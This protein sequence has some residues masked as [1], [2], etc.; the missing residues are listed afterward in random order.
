MKPVPANIMDLSKMAIE[1]FKEYANCRG[2]QDIILE[3]KIGRIN[4]VIAEKAYSQ[5]KNL[6]LSLLSKNFLSNTSPFKF[7]AKLSLLPN[8][9]DLQPLIIPNLCE[10][11][12]TICVITFINYLVL[13]LLL[14]CL[15]VYE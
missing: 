9:R 15:Y 10:Y 2:Y 5:G 8:Q 7:V 12:F 13:V 14:Y 1:V 11:G 4:A 3:G 6:Y